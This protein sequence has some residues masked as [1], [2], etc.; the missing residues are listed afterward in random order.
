[1]LGRI[2]ALIIILKPVLSTQI[3]NSISFI[4]NQVLIGCL[5]IFGV[6]L[7]QLPL[8]FCRALVYNNICIIQRLIF[9]KNLDLK[10]ALK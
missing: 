2:T 3:V 10:D 6:L 5:K 9:Y 8:S 7:N 1:M 4:E